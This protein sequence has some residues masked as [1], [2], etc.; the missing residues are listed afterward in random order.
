MGNFNDFTA[1]LTDG[2]TQLAK[3]EIPGLVNEL[4]SSGNQ[5]AVSLEQDIKQWTAQLASGAIDSDDFQSLV[6]GKADIFDMKKITAKGLAQARV[7]AIEG[8]V[9]D[10]IVQTALKVFVPNA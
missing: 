9:T 7:D 8:M 1:N 2:L 4:V 3:K 5:F 10:L 6:K